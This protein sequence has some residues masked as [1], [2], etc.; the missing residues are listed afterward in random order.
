MRPP[1]LRYSNDY[2]SVV[3]R[4]LAVQHEKSAGVA[5]YQSQ[6]KAAIN[7]GLFRSVVYS[8]LTID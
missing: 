2:L 5:W 7:G 1:F 4:A 8:L 6:E 3:S